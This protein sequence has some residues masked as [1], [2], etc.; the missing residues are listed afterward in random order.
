MALRNP[1]AGM[2]PITSGILTLTAF[3]TVFQILDEN[4]PP[5]VLDQILVAVFGIWFAAEAK[6]N[7][8]QRKKVSDDADSE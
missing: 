3:W 7:S 5:V 8:D 4:D 1:L 2:R 6:R